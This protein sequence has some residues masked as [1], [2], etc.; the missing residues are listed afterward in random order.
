MSPGAAKSLTRSG[1]PAKQWRT[2]AGWPA[3]LEQLRLHGYAEGKNLQIEFRS[4]EG[5][6]GRLPELA[7]ELASLKFDVLSGIPNPSLL[8]LQRATRT[9]PIVIMSH[10][11]VE[12]GLVASLARPGGNITGIDTLAPELDEKRLQLLREAIPKASRIAALFSPARDRAMRIHMTQTE[13]AASALG[14]SVRPIEAERVEDFEGIFAALKSD[15]PDALIAFTDS[16]IFLHR[17][18]IVDFARDQRL[19]TVFEFREFTVSGGLMSYGNNLVDIY[20]RAADYVHR[21]LE[22]AK[23]ADLPVERPNRYELVLN[24][25][26]ATAL[27]LSIPRSLLLKADE[28]IQQRFVAFFVQAGSGLL[29]KQSEPHPGSLGTWEAG[30]N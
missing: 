16:V 23:P 19:A 20:R 15:R 18:R 25:N 10:A 8:A 7:A 21:I 30:S 13:H 4:A 11:A 26:A 28:V 12:V 22:G 5:N 24:L 27:G 29:G 2:L 14:Y 17:Q 3:F 1:V 6:W 9:T